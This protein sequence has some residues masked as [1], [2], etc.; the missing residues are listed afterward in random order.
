MIPPYDH[1]ALW[2]KAKLF[3]NR[4]MEPDSDRAFE[5]RAFWAAAALEL[6]GKAALA[7][8]SPLLIAEPKEDG[9]NILIAAGVLKGE[10][11]FVS[12][13][14]ATVFRRCARAFV[15]F[16]ADGAIRVAN[17]RNEY[18]HSPAS[19]LSPLPEAQW[20]AQYWSLA[21]TLIEA[22]DRKLTDLVGQS[23]VEAV[24]SYLAQNA[25]NIEFRTQ[26]LIARAK[27]RFD[28]ERDGSAPTKVQADW[29]NI[30]KANGQMQ[31]KL[32]QQCPACSSMGIIEGDENID[33]ETD[34]DSWDEEGAV[35][36]R[37]TVPSERF[38]CPACRLVLDS[39]PLIEEAGLPD[40]FE[41][42]DDAEEYLEPDYGND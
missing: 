3:L 41:V 15:P 33:V 22:Q 24:E 40:H 9:K 1:E 25:K 32:E 18:M 10:A 12:V 23:R 13:S 38:S 35:L 27:Q 37:V 42:L 4:A 5:E 29:A 17:G 30:I 2:L 21:T 11:R 20:W 19:G 14:A 7:K 31:Y 28:F 39:L 8:I 36:V 6:L 34:Y 26:S 16:D